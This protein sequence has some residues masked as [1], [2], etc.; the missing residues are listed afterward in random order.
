MKPIYF[1]LL[2]TIFFTS[3]NKNLLHLKHKNNFKERNTFLTENNQTELEQLIFYN[4]VNVIDEEYTHVLILTIKDKDAAEQKRHL[5]LQKDTAIIE[6]KYDFFSVWDWDD[7]NLT[8]KGTVDIVDWTTKSIKIKEN[9]EVNDIRRNS[10]KKYK[11][12]RTFTKKNK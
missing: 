1:L 2:T 7:E 4:E 3:C 10:I 6:I 5:D 12:K 8:I 9:I 11:G